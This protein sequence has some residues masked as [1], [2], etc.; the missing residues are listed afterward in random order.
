LRVAGAPLLHHFGDMPI[1]RIDQQAIDRAAVAIRPDGA[2]NRRSPPAFM[3]LTAAPANPSGSS[4]V[5]A[6]GSW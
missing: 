5:L 4:R 6:G 1:D 3:Y 2:M